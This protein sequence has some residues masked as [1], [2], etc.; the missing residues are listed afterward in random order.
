MLVW[1]KRV[2]AF[3][4][5][6]ARRFCNTRISKNEIGSHLQVYMWADSTREWAVYICYCRRSS[7]QTSHPYTLNFADSLAGQSLIALLDVVVSYETTTQRYAFFSK[8][9]SLWAEILHFGGKINWEMTFLQVLFCPFLSTC[10]NGWLLVT[11][12]SPNLLGTRKYKR[13]A[14]FPFAFFSFIRNFAAWYRKSWNTRLNVLRV[15]NS[16][17]HAISRSWATYY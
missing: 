8:V 7:F 2:W 10:K 3:L 11:L 5:S 1:Y 12:V 6:L 14:R 17:C 15:T 13:K 16:E 4:T 9:E